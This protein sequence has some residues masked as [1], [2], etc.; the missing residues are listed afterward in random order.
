MKHPAAE[1]LAQDL[2]R[3]QH[4][5]E[6]GETGVLSIPGFHTAGMSDEQ[7]AE[8]IGMIGVGLCEAMIETL[9][10]RHGYVVIS[11]DQLDALTASAAGP[12][13]GIDGVP[14]HCN[15]CR[16]PVIQRLRL[17]NPEFVKINTVAVLAALQAHIETCCA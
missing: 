17:T 6:H 16:V 10:V 8:T 4:T 15:R 2:G 12:D 5:N 13:Q 14:I 9:D 3:L 11:R 7:A 1:L